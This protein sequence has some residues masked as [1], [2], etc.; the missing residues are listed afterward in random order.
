VPL[1]CSWTPVGPVASGPCDAPARPP[2]ASRRR[3]STLA[4]SGLYRTAL[5]LAVYASQS[6][7]TPRPRK[8]RFRLLARLCRTGLFTRRVPS[9]GFKDVS[10][11]SSSFLRHAYR[12]MLRGARSASEGQGPAV[13]VVRQDPRLRLRLGLGFVPRA[14]KTST[15]SAG[16]DLPLM[17]GESPERRESY[18]P[19]LP[20]GRI[21]R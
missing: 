6:R 2:F 16:I 5:A 21:L 9:K 18:V 19:F 10:Y 14:L 11:I 3:L 20:V 13:A 4:L 8:T 15:A 17:S 7:V 1:P 12:G